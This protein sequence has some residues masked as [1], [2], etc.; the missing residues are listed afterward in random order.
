VAFGGE[1]V[2]VSAEPGSGE[3]RA[4]HGGAAFCTGCDYLLG[5]YALSDADF[6]LS[7]S[8][9]GPPSPSRPHHH[10]LTI[11]LSPSRSHPHAHNHSHPRPRAHPHPHPHPR[12]VGA[13]GARQLCTVLLEGVP[14]SGTVDS[15]ET[16]CFAFELQHTDKVLELPTRS[17]PPNPHPHPPPPPPPPTRRAGGRALAHLERG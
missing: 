8:V 2:L 6:S 10:A 9:V 5:V 13:P 7:F 11:T 3:V 17:L 4:A 15:D 12:Q 16:R 14:F 1:E